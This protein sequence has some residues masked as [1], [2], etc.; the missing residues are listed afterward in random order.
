MTRK[1]IGLSR[2]PIYV[3]LSSHIVK[4]PSNFYVYM[5]RFVPP[6]NLGE[7]NFLL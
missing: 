7:R 3:S 2:K 1:V 6:Y 5:Y 4:L